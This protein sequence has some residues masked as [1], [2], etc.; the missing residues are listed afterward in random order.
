MVE[1]SASSKLHCTIEEVQANFV[2]PSANVKLIKGVSAQST[3]D[4][5]KSTLLDKALQAKKN[6]YVNLEKS[7]R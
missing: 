7:P 2:Q 1:I 3:I 6:S 5:R 4:L